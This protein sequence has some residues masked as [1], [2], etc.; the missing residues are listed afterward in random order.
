MPEITKEFNQAS[1]KNF[2]KIKLYKNVK[3]TLAFLKR[4]KI[5]IAIVT[6]KNLKGLN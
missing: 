6:S 5:K 3:Q 4:R 2:N 1:I